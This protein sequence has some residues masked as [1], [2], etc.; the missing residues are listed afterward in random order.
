MKLQVRY[1]ILVIACTSIFLL[2][3]CASR[4]Y[5]V[6]SANVPLL[7][8]KGD[9]KATAAL[10]TSGVDL[11]AAYAFHKNIAASLTGSLPMVVNNDYE[12]KSTELYGAL[13]GL[14]P[15][16]T[17]G[18]FEVYGGGGGGRYQNG[19]KVSDLQR[20]FTQFDVGITEN[21]FDVAFLTR[22]AY[23]NLDRTTYSPAV[24]AFIIEP[25]IVARFGFRNLKL[26]TQ[27]ML[28]ITPHEQRNIEIIPI[29]L[30]L[31]LQTTFNFSGQ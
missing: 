10:S 12:E 28:A 6:P 18:I 15:F 22:L 19:S 7:R 1:C 4:R 9:L 11:H 23:L 3:H 30:S 31:G 25:G 16:G 21:N 24:T 5:Y 17:N 27:L 20:F 26:E 13:G 8:Q 2:G 29:M 14:F